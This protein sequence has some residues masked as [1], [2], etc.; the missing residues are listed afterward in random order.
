MR[1]RLAGALGLTRS[2][3]DPHS[4]KAKT[5]GELSRA[6]AV[7]SHAKPPCGGGLGDALIVPQWGAWGET[8]QARCRQSQARKHLGTPIS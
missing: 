1:G 8:P 3:S 2:G 4:G 5:F 6:A 7:A